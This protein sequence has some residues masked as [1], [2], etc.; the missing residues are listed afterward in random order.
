MYPLLPQLA[1]HSKAGTGAGET[2]PEV[3]L[4]MPVPRSTSASMVALSP[5]GSVLTPRQVHLN[6]C[7]HV[8]PK[9]SKFF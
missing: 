2:G 4:L 8:H 9:Y 1:S 6:F 7:A 5:S 3:T